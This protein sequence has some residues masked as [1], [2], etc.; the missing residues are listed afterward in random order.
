MT[1]PFDPHNH[2]RGPLTSG[3]RVR[4]DL[5][6]HIDRLN[7]PWACGPAVLPA[8]E[9]RENPIVAVKKRG[10]KNKPVVEAP[11]EPTETAPTP[12]E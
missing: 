5:R 4:P 11:V 6:S 1:N 10:R 7:G 3:P 8:I 9:A 2:D 12:V